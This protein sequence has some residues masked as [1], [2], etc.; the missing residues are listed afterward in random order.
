MSGEAVL[1]CAMFGFAIL[2]A[3]IWMNSNRM[4]AIEYKTDCLKKMVNALEEMLDIHEQD[5][6]SFESR[7]KHLKDLVESKK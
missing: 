6:K 7:I 2:S 3:A 4:N 5:I 1:L